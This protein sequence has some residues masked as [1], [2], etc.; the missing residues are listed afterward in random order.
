M[1]W[2]KK[3]HGSGIHQMC[4][5]VALIAYCGTVEKLTITTEENGLTWQMATKLGKL[6][7]KFGNIQHKSCMCGYVKH[8]PLLE[9]NQT[10][11]T[12]F[13]FHSSP[14]MNEEQLQEIFM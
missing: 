3:M 11:S 1:K 6:R 8:S 7:F 9:L 2:L 13:D 5:S 10:E 12:L 4:S 14:I